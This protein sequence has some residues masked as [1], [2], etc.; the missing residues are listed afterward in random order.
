[1]ELLQQEKEKQETKTK[2]KNQKKRKR[3]EP[4]EKEIYNIYINLERLKLIFIIKLT[5]NNK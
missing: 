5:L 4:K 3:K 1:M 2:K